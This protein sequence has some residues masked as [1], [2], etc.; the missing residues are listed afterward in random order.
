MNP[1]VLLRLPE[2]LRRTALA[3]SSLY[4]LVGERRFP[5]PVKIGTRA[6][7][8]VEAEVDE[9]LH[10]RAAERESR[11]PCVGPPSALSRR[12]RTA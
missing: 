2:V 9:W 1:L 7:A 6:S 5:P 3:R 11:I 12:G 4:K 8:W 10:A